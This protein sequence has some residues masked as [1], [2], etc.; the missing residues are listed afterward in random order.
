MLAPAAITACHRVLVVQIDLA[1]PRSDKACSRWLARAVIC[2][3]LGS[4]RSC[5]MVARHLIGGSAFPRSPSMCKERINTMSESLIDLVFSEEETLS[6]RITGRGLGG[7]GG[8]LLG[9]GRE[10]LYVCILHRIRHLLAKMNAVR[11][12]PMVD[13]RSPQ[14]AKPD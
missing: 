12:R 7:C 1:R 4:E 10:S 14:S 5:A 6:E 13:G 2:A 11:R 3:E 8:Q 9:T